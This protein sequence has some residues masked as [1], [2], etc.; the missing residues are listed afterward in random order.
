M[1]ATWG[2]ARHSLGLLA[3]GLCSDLWDSILLALGHEL[4]DRSIEQTI[5]PSTYLSTVTWSCLEGQEND[6]QSV[7]L[8]TS[9]TYSSYLRSVGIYRLFLLF[10]FGYHELAYSSITCLYPIFCWCCILYT[11]LSTFSSSLHTSHIPN[12]PYKPLT[13]HHSLPPDLTL[14]PLSTFSFP[15][16]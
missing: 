14:S 15:L 2:Q 11:Y 13:Y 9:P 8:P 10:S 3:L 1:A 5:S 4:I 6:T 7:Y 12:S 16:T